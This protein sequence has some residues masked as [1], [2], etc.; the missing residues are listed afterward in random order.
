MGKGLQTLIPFERG[1]AELPRLRRLSR[2]EKIEANLNGSAG[3]S[4]G[5]KG[6]DGVVRLERGWVGCWKG[7]SLHGAL[8]SAHPPYTTI[9]DLVW[10]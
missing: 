8:P 3:F 1:I 9:G 6:L 2:L 10:P 4:E 5:W 7:S